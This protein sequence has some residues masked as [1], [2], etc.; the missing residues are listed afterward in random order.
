MSATILSKTVPKS[1]SSSIS[2]PVSDGEAEQPL[3][4]AVKRLRTGRPTPDPS[5]SCSFR[6]AVCHRSTPGRL[7]A[8]RADRPGPMRFS[9]KS[10]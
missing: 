4:M 5:A 10:R 8:I 3:R 9:P 6:S 1:S 2:L 7:A